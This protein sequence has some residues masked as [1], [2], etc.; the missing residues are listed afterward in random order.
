MLDFKMVVNDNIEMELWRLNGNV[1]A[2]LAHSE[3]GLP[4]MRLH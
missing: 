2:L 4:M 3:T 1:V